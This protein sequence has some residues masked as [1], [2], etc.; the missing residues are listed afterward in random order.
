MLK[1]WSEWTSYPGGLAGQDTQAHRLAMAVI[2]SAL[3]SLCDC[4]AL[5]KDARARTL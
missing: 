3:F 2:M 4:D 1:Q 5:K